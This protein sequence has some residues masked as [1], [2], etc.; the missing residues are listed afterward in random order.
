MTGETSL[1]DYLSSLPDIE[2]EGRS[3]LKLAALVGPRYWRKDLFGTNEGLAPI[4][5]YQSRKPA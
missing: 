4:L 5:K 3:T 2:A 1:N